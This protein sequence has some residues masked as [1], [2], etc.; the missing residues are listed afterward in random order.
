MPS[1]M[2]RKTV[3]R[4]ASAIVAATAVACLYCAV[5]SVE[6]TPFGLL[7]GPLVAL[8]VVPFLTL[9]SICV[10][11]WPK[12]LGFFLPV[13]LMVG[14]CLYQIWLLRLQAARADVSE[15]AEEM[16]VYFT[17]CYGLGLCF[18]FGYLLC[19]K[20]DPRTMR[21]MPATQSPP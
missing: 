9:E 19:V 21:T 11:R 5:V 10:A 7:V 18:A 6:T 4:G 3:W 17:Q 15:G 16:V 12:Y 13:L 20:R 14:G 8:S 1:I 2:F